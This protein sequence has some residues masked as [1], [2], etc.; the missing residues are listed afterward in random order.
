MDLHAYDSF[1]R[2]QYEK[3]A[4][5]VAGILAAAVRAKGS[6][7]LQQVQHRA[8]STESLR[9]KLIKAGAEQTT[10]IEAV[11]KDLAGC[12]LI[13][14]SNTDVANFLRSG[15]IFDNFEIDWNRTRIH[16]P[17]TA[18]GAGD[19]H[20]VAN[21]YVVRLKPDRARLPEY[22]S[23]AGLWCEVQVQTILNHAWSELAHDTIYKHPD[24]G[25]IGRA[26][27]QRIEDRM[28]RIM[29]E[30]LLPAGYEFQ[31]VLDDFERLAAGKQ[32]IDTDCLTAI[33]NAPNNN[34]RYDMLERFA[35]E[36]LPLY[37][38][39][40]AILPTIR[41]TL[42]QAAAAA[43]ET[44][45]VPH[46]TS[47]GEFPGRT[48]DDVISRILTV[49][50]EVRYVD[51]ETVFD[52]YA[53]LFVGATSELQRQTILEKV[54]RLSQYELDVWRRI[55]PLVQ[56]RLLEIVQRLA[57]ARRDEIRPLVTEVLRS[58]LS[59]EITGTSSSSQ[60]VTWSAAAVSPTDDLLRVRT[61]AIKLLDAQLSTATNDGDRRDVVRALDEATRMPQRGSYGSTLT[62][63]FLRDAQTV[64][65]IYT[66]QLSSLGHKIAQEIEYNLLF[67]HRRNKALPSSALEFDGVT[68]ARDELL[69]AIF[70][71][72]DIANRD[73][74]FAIFKLLIGY[75]SVFD[76]Q[77]DEDEST[78]E[79]A[80]RNIERYQAYLAAEVE[81]LAGR[82]C[83]KNGGQWF[84][85]ILRYITTYADALRDSPQLGKFL[86]KVAARE[87][88][89][90]VDWLAKCS[91]PPLAVLQPP[92]LWGLQISNPEAAR[93]HIEAAIR[94]GF[95][96]SE[97]MRYLKF[98]KPTDGLLAEKALAKAAAASDT[99]AAVLALE[100][101]TQRAGDIGTE[102]ARRL[103]LSAI[104]CLDHMGEFGWVDQIA[105]H[106]RRSGLLAAFTDD[107][108]KRILDA[109][110]NVP[111]LDYYGEVLLAGVA[112]RLPTEVVE[113]LGLRFARQAT[114]ENNG[115]GPPVRKYQALPDSL[116]KLAAPLAGHMAFVVDRAFEWSRSDLRLSLFRGARLVAALCPDWHPDLERKLMEY[117]RSGDPN[118]HIFLL[119][120]LRNYEGQ[121]FIHPVAQ[122][123]VASLPE[124]NDLEGEI[125]IALESTGILHGEFGLRDAYQRVKSLMEGWLT[126]SR[127][128]VVAFAQRM[129]RHLDNQIAAEQRSVEESIAMRRLAFG[130]P[131][132]SRESG[133]AT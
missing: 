21:N 8:K 38:D 7:R 102:T 73:E 56:M 51:V 97:V 110:I 66:R 59:P 96:L 44:Q 67:L 23:V 124:E 4:A 80:D 32:L 9:A 108:L 78:D 3:L 60:S 63:Q 98:A 86:E 127:T 14:Y 43:R 91:S 42:L 75:Q 58:C 17:G 24:L 111:K 71:F 68:A 118:K 1:G 101:A 20:F 81:K 54:S 89:V 26:Q 40:E 131:L 82:V 115:S 46:S 133:E 119:R 5:T 84:D 25:G 116:K 129:I 132:I 15:I 16:Q 64:V 74:D 120:V 33:V 99:R 72:R 37:D 28:K 35:D 57:P 77:W 121:K 53:E 31:K 52:A 113:S 109:L 13:F 18:Q 123:L 126:D 27:M 70:R 30:Y 47:I 90:G 94:E 95:F 19:S 11:A 49:F 62:L 29:T 65:E 103:T 125:E 48:P 41:E 92:L 104:D 6:I 112:P 122:E 106:G 50:D 45:T 61:D 117:A 10:E 85:R 83:R 105:M 79:N 114:A 93:S 39:F 107:E 76:F 34:E 100:L 55:G 36:V 130:E 2:L 69:T 12:R 22:T 128:K 87:P 88:E